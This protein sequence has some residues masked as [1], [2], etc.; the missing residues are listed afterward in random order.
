MKIISQVKYME[1]K[2]F[3][4][5]RN[6]MKEKIG[7]ATINDDN[8]YGNR[9]QNYA[10]Q[11]IIKKVNNDYEVE[12][13][14]NSS[15]LN[16]K[17]NN[18]IKGC[19]NKIK[20]IK[21]LI[22]KKKNKSERIACFKQFNKNI[23]YSKKTFNFGKKMD[24]EYKYFVAGSDQIWNPNFNRLTDFDLLSFA[25]PE[26]R[27]AFSASF[28]VSEISET[29]SQKAKKE[30]KKYKAI[31]VREEAGKEIIQK[32]NI[33]KDVQVLIDPTMLLTA[34]E[35]DKVAKKPEQLKTDKYILNYFLGELS[36]SRKKEIEKIAKENNYEIIN[37]LDKNSPFYQTGPSEFL[38]LEKNAFLICA[39]SFHSCVFAILFNVP[40]IVFEREGKTAKMNS[41]IETLL[42]KFELN[43]NKFEGKI[44]KE[45]LEVD[46][47]NAYRI[48]EEER[49][50]AMNFIKGAIN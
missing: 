40:F 8:N 6:D 13:I 49:K 18:L 21:Y 12:T 28:G 29:A 39:D 45:Q 16:K 4:F 38:Y 15:F 35:W 14:K 42:N 22:I 27:V 47:T 34:E 37:I 36:E 10:V 24:E 25:T 5:R 20:F 9:L 48:L 41:R 46:Y 50:K 3:Y 1:N 23:K 30:L 43:N 31:S 32:M 44:T 33:N 17:E 19:I 2:K 11:Q 26:K 7:I